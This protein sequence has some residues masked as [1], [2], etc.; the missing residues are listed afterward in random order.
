M[1]G[2]DVTSESCPHYLTLNYQE[3][4]S[5]YGPLAKIAPPLRTKK[6]NEEQWNGINDGS[7]DFIATDHAPHSE[8]EK[9]KKVVRNLIIGL[10]VI[11]ILLIGVSQMI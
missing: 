6:D 10:V 8:E 7:I 3:S 9:A 2:I 4:M 11:A 1:R 5:K